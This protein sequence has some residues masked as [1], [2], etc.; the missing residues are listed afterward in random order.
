MTD[1]GV[2]LTWAAIS[3]ASVKGLS[4][5]ARAALTSNAEIELSPP[6]SD[7]SLVLGSLRSIGAAPHSARRVSLESVVSS[8]NAPARARAEQ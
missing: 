3:A 4:V 6:G 8:T 7:P 1:L 5:L 2:A